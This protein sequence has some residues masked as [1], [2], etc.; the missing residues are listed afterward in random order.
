MVNNSPAEPVRDELTSSFP[1]KEPGNED[2]ELMVFS[3]Q[4]NF[5]FNFLFQSLTRDISHSKENLAIDSLLKWKL[6]E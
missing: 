5:N 3:D 1:G 6:I 4:L 2:D